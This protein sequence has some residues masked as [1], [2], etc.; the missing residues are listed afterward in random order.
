[1]NK[2]IMSHGFVIIAL[3]VLTIVANAI[4]TVDETEQ[5]V[6]TRFGEPIG[7]PIKAPGL[8]V[9]VPFIDHVNKFEKRLLEWDGDPNRIPTQ[10]KKYIWI[11][12]TARWRIVDPLKFL[13]TVHNERQAQSRLDGILDGAARNVIARHVLL[14]TVRNSNR[15]L[16]IEKSEEDKMMGRQYEKIAEGTGREVITR[17]MLAQARP[18]VEK[19]GIDLVD[20]WIKR[21]NYEPKVRSKVF[22]RMISERKRAAEL[23]RAEGQGARA[24]I[25]GKKHKELQRIQ[26]EAYREA[27]VLRG[28]ADATVTKIYA[29]AYSKDPEFYSFLNTLAG[30][31]RALSNESTLILSTS[32]EYFKYLDELI[33][34]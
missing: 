7:K 1:M 22:D 26:S 21:V 30:Y 27:Q 12:S 16:T 8:H 20:I 28:K 31:Q 33:G 18:K 25:E 32:N 15:I 19:F 34:E 29:D 23:L 10:D 4:Y 17:E 14:E 2:T 5:I 24:E 3:I 13:Q 11:D 9:K 6:I